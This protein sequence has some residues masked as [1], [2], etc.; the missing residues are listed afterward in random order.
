MTS[1]R[2]ESA[3]RVVALASLSMFFT[4]CFFVWGFVRL[5]ADAWP[6]PGASPLPW[7]LP[8]ACLAL[9][10]L[11]SFLLERARSGWSVVAVGCAVLGL[12]GLLLRGLVQAG[13]TPG[14]LGVPGAVV[15]GLLGV[16]G[17]SVLVAVCGL[18]S[19]AG[20]PRRWAAYW[21]LLSAMTAVALV[22]VFLT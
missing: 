21:H 5:S 8:C 15:L 4:A 9:M 16:Q 11:G 19:A 14:Q 12:Q 1:V 22:A 2:V 20:A 6:P 18:A 10:V 17:L 13:W 3:G 7:R